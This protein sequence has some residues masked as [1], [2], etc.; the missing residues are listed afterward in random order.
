MVQ[1]GLRRVHL[2]PLRSR[3]GC[4][5][6]RSSRCVPV[7][8]AA[9]HHV[10]VP[11]ED[12]EQAVGSDP[13]LLDEIERVRRASWPSPLKPPVPSPDDR[14]DAAGDR[15]LVLGRGPPCRLMSCLASAF[16]CAEM[17]SDFSQGR[18]RPSRRQVARGPPGL[19]AVVARRRRRPHLV[20]VRLLT[21]WPMCDGDLVGH[22]DRGAGRRVE[23]HAPGGAGARAS[24]T[25]AAFEAFDT[26]ASFARSP[27]ASLGSWPSFLS[28]PIQALWI[29]LVAVRPCPASCCPRTSRGSRGRR[30]RRCARAPPRG[31]HPGPPRTKG[32]EAES[33]ACRLPPFGDAARNAPAGPTACKDARTGRL[34]RRLQI[35]GCG[36]LAASSYRSLHESGGPCLFPAYPVPRSLAALDQ[37]RPGPSPAA[38]RPDRLPPAAQGPGESWLRRRQGDPAPLR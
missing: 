18:S 13:A 25:R 7:R 19:V 9:A 34:Q 27:R 22:S 24:A 8:G 5:T 26:A 11:V 12:V 14:V 2:R 6:R 23:R 29:F 37:G 35:P 4:R 30:P 33:I 36:R 17:P 21:I 32:H 3:R 20:R 28:R 16:A 38:A 15:C 1:V 31:R 10:V